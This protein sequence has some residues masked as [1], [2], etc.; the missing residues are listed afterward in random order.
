[1]RGQ[2]NYNMKTITSISGGKTSAYL[3]KHYP[4]DENIFALVRIEDRKCTPKDKTLVQKVSDKIGMEFIATAESDTTLTLMFDLEQLLG[5]EII[6]TTGDTFEQVCLKRK[7]LPNL[8]MRFCTTEMKMKPIFEFCYNHFGMVEMNIGFRFD[9][10]ERA[11]SQNTKFKTIVGQSANGR[12]KWAEI[13][14]RECKY[15]LIENRIGHYQVGQWANSTGLIFPPDSNC[16]GCFWKNPQQ[17]RKNFDDEPLKMQWFADMEEKLKR[18][19]KKEMSYDKIKTI[20]LQQDFYF[21]TGSGC[22]AGFCTD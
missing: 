6:W 10:M 8:M 12:N 14:W 4:T 2:L 5:K 13:E 21:G 11:N 16:V 19:W 20:G 3:A 7:A 15:P 9:E 22:Q 1:V 17:L 18:K